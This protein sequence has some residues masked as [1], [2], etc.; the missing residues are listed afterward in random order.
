MAKTKKEKQ[1]LVTKYTDKLSAAKAVYIIRPTQITPNEAN[2]LRK[3]LKANDAS[4]S[5]VKNSLFKLALEKAD[6]KIDSIEFE[7]ENA[8]VFCNGEVSESAKILDTFM[9]DQQKGEFRGGLL[10]TTQLSKIDIEQLAELPSKDIMI[11]T[12]VRMIAA[13]L[14][15]F[16]N[17]LNGN[18]LNLVNVLKNISKAE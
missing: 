10:D 5:V 7:G 14:S 3:Q 17:V 18:I 9:K 4:M 11:A 2:A 12:T 1:E 13:P 16:M 6:K 8:A 15:S